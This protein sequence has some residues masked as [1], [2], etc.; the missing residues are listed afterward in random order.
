MSL[1][2]IT[3]LS[4]VVCSVALVSLKLWL[5]TFFYILAVLF[6]MFFC[7]YLLVRMQELKK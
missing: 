6:I 2:A 1:P 4:V 5:F 3:A 7:P